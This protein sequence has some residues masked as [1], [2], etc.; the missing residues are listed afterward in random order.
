MTARS[1]DTIAQGFTAPG[2]KKKRLVVNFE[3]GTFYDLH[4]RALAKHQSMNSYIRGLIEDALDRL[5]GK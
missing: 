2:G 1:A 3:L 5:D 4:H